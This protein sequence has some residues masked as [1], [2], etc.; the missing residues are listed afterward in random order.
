M[1]RYIVLCLA[2]VIAV[3]F[4]ACSGSYNTVGSSVSDMSNPCEF[5]GIAMDLPKGFYTE[6][7]SDTGIMNVYPEDYPDCSD[8]I[9]L[10]S[11]GKADDIANYSKQEI[12]KT[13]S[14]ALGEAF[15]GIE[16]Y[17]NRVISD[18][19]VV[20]TSYTIAY[21]DHSV[22]QIQLTVLLDDDTV[23]ITFTVTSDKYKDEFEKT[24]DSLIIG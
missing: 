11:A 20:V 14:T 16:R 22:D 21:A 18:H 2:L 8:N 24:I 6:V 4:S 10:I 5:K 12:N 15:K 17:E 9:C 7:A 3:S 23:F 13:F 1:K 19:D